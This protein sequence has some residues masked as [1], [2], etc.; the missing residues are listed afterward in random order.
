MTNEVLPSRCEDLENECRALRCPYGIHRTQ[1]DSGCQRCE[2]ANPCAEYSCP[3]GQKCAVEISNSQ[4]GE[5]I[6]V[7]RLVNKPGDCP[8]L[9][10]PVNET[11]IGTLGCSRECYDDADCRTDNKC[12][13]NGCSFVCVRPQSAYHPMRPQMPVATTPA[14]IYPGEVRASLEPKTQS[15]LDVHTPVGGIAILRCFATGNPA[16][17]I[18]WSFNNLMVSEW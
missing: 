6:P 10:A 7:C 13:N 18:T 12:C 2:C 8:Q 11:A 9:T 3:D 5:F 4:S 15:E 14:I 17:N 16:P 1:E